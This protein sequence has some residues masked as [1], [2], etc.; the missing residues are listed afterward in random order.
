LLE[1]QVVLVTLDGGYHSSSFGSVL[2]RV[3]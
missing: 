1:L 2:L 3:R